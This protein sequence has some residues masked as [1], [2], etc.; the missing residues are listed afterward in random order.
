MSSAKL[1]TIQRFSKTLTAETN[2]IANRRRSE[3]ATPNTM[4]MSLST[5][6]KKFFVSSKT[7]FT[8]KLCKTMATSQVIDSSANG[9]AGR[10]H[11]TFSVEKRY[12]TY[13]GELKICSKQSLHKLADYFCKQR[14]GSAVSNR[15]NSQLRKSGMNV[16]ELK[17]QRKSSARGGKIA[18]SD[19]IDKNLYTK[20]AKPASRAN[21]AE[22]RNWDSMNKRQGTSTEPKQVQF[23]Q[24][25]SKLRGRER[26]TQ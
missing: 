23:S 5:Q 19:L 9:H 13:N 1:A 17:T 16:A 6:L 2:S 20:D 8:S 21:L 25:C 12:K 14:V 22:Y 18:N 11:K 4:A 15:E 26:G 10:E 3:V 7:S 24:T